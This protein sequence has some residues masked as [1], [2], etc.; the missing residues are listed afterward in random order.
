MHNIGFERGRDPKEV[1]S[2]GILSQI[3]NEM[4]VAGWVQCDPDVT[5]VDYALCW[6]TK[7]NH[8]DYVKFL[9]DKG[10]ETSVYKNYSLGYAMQ[11]K[12]YK[13]VEVLIRAGADIYAG[14]QWLHY[15]QV[16]TE[17]R[18]MEEFL[19]K[20]DLMKYKSR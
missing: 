12:F 6:A 18:E 4:A 10:A 13:L 20:N 19:I 15:P 17:K 5:V 1:L 14:L 2:V 8:I 7:H 9:L 3:L 11:N 16:N